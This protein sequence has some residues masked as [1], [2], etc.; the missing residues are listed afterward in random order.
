MAIAGNSGALE[1]EVK[2]G[3]V[4]EEV[5]TKCIIEQRELTIKAK[6]QFIDYE[7]RSD[8]ESIKKIL[9][10]MKPKNLIVI[11]G[12]EKSTKEMMEYCQNQKIVQ[13]RI[14]T[15]K[16]NE[17]V[18]ATLETQIYNVKLKDELVSS[19]KFQKVKD[20]ELAWVDAIIKYNTSNESVEAGQNSELSSQQN[21]ETGL[22]LHPLNKE[23]MREHRTVFVNEPKLS[24]LKQIFMHNSIQA[25]FHGGVL[26]CNGIVALKK[27]TYFNKHKFRN[28][29]INLSLYISFF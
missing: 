11:H 26:V 9:S 6:M 7:G 10:N 3:L 22:S 16:T 21:L 4:E 20:Y 13:S 1:N 18:N 5:P 19:L 2:E 12:N 15:P 14:F 28:Y 29:S 17:F 27:V 8:G 23:N 25:E 24:D